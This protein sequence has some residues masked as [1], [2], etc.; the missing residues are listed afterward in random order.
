MLFSILTLMFMYSSF[1]QAHP[2]PPELRSYVARQILQKSAAAL[3]AHN[4]YES[5]Y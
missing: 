3:I 4:G 1:A 5:M 2:A